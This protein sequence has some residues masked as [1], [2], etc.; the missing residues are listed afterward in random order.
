MKHSEVFNILKP[1]ALDLAEER[2]R[3]VAAIVYKNK[4]VS[5]G[6][7][8]MKSHP[9]QAKYSKNDEAIF[10]HAETNA[11]Y[12]AL[13]ITDVDTLKK[14][15]LY[16]CRVKKDDDKS[17]L[18]GLSK[19]CAGCQECILDHKIPTLIY[20]LDGKFGKHRYLIEEDA[21]YR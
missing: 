18:F 4:I 10:W 3:H 19:P 5:F 14:C 8:H 11:I 20:T 15:S 21:N 13:K 9:F 16:V 7:S 6:T 12:N 1:V 17:M 2:F